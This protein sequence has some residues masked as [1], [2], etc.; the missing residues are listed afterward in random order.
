MG[1]DDQNSCRPVIEDI[2]VQSERAAAL[3]GWHM[4]LVVLLSLA[5]EREGCFPREHFGELED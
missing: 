1:V 5:E 3:V 2:L 4:V